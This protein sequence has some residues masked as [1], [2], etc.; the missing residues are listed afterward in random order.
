M[1]P[2]TSVA[3]RGP[4]VGRVAQ[5]ADDQTLAECG[6]GPMVLLLLV[7]K[8]PF[9]PPEH[10]AVSGEK[11]ELGWPVVAVDPSGSRGEVSKVYTDLFSERQWNSPQWR[12][13]DSPSN[14]G[15]T[16]P[17]LPAEAE[18]GHPPAALVLVPLVPAEV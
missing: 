13:E 9:S 7:K 17:K 11:V 18:A 12:G 14:T 3:P 4:C 16:E 1:L 6:V 2:A 15:A 10:V 5:L 8:A